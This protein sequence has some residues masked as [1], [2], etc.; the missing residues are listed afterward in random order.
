MLSAVG[1]LVAGVVVVAIE[2][3]VPGL[4]ALSLDEVGEAVE[5]PS[6]ELLLPRELTWGLIVLW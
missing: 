4:G 5:E 2:S 1:G 6:M 3:E